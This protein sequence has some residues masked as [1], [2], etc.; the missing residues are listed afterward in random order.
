[1][2]R[3]RDIDSGLSAAYPLSREAIEELPLDIADRELLAAIMAEPQ[4]ASVSP[5]EPRRRSRAARRLG[6]FAVTGAAAA[7]I[8]LAVFGVGGGAPGSPAP[9]YG[10]RLLRLAEISPHILLDPSEWVITVTETSKALEG[11]TEFQ[12]GKAWQDDPPLGRIAKFRWHSVSLEKREAEVLAHGA[13]AT[14][15]APVL[16]TT[17]QVL[18]YRQRAEGLLLA[19]ALWD[20]G[21]R[22]FEFRTAVPDMAGFERRL[23]DLERVDMD[24]WL[25]A[26]GEA[27]LFDL[28]SK[29][30]RQ[31]EQLR[32]HLR[33]T[34]KLWLFPEATG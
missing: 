8:F 2:S 32:R 10:A 28:L 25:A 30:L 21:G 1:V 15:T 7:T 3:N 22:A 9:A 18:T 4:E 17:A 23:A 5:R 33:N 19:T 20:Q 27:P 34:G 31:S 11:W 6:G 26:V 16:G 12:R 24:T 13:T 29:H 14:T